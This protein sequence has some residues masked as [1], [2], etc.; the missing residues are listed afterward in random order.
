MN[1]YVHT[2]KNINSHCIFEQ[3]MDGFWDTTNSSDYISCH[4]IIYIM[5]IYVK[6]PCRKHLADRSFYTQYD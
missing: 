6:W 4:N 2:I 1:M 3:R 5:Y